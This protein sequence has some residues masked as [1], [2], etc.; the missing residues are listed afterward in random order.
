M[1]HFLYARHHLHAQTLSLFKEL[2]TFDSKKADEG[3]E[4]F[5]KQLF[6]NAFST[7]R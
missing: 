4:R 5:G 7:W 2:L 6:M 1:F 3:L